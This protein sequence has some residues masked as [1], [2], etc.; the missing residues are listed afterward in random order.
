MKKRFLMLCF[1]TSS[2]FLDSSMWGM[3]EEKR[4]TLSL[5]DI[6]GNEEE[7]IEELRNRF[8][9][10]QA[11]EG[12]KLLIKKNER[13]EKE[14]AEL[15]EQLD[16]R[17]PWKTGQPQTRSWFTSFSGIL[18]SSEYKKEFFKY[19]KKS[20]IP[21][22]WELAWNFVLHGSIPSTLQAA[23]LWGPAGAALLKDA[24]WSGLPTKEAQ[25]AY[26]AIQQAK[27][28]YKQIDKRIKE[29]GHEQTDCKK[30]LKVY[31]LRGQQG[32]LETQ[33][34]AQEN[35]KKIG[36]QILSES[37][38]QNSNRSSALTKAYK[39]SLLTL[40]AAKKTPHLGVPIADK[41]G[42]KKDGYEDVINMT[43][44]QYLTLDQERLMLRAYQKQL[45]EEVI[46]TL[47]QKYHQA[48]IN[49]PGAPL[50]R[51]VYATP[52]ATWSL[53]RGT[54]TLPGKI[55]N[56]AYDTI[57]EKDTQKKIA[58]I[59]GGAALATIT[60]AALWQANNVLKSLS[61][62]PLF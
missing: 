32:D 47:E 39:A 42:N 24:L 30:A 61:N 3:E 4:K 6:D 2:L 48:I 5:E 16:K 29:I 49:N 51:L 11:Q 59:G 38:K 60:G 15:R 58:I 44:Q 41:S 31:I 55:C 28:S 21:L 22:L 13:L 40:E 62:L 10:E 50:K 45:K 43:T 46:P 12:A 27:L 17:M 57:P 20:S 33:R 53:A 35:L 56:K 9:E 7:S 34:I 23:I 18:P 14:N 1:L 37:Q 8:R 19:G 26:I 25:E 54:I 36:D 52:N